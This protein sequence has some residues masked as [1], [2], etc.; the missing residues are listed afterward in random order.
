M[1]FFLDTAPVEALSFAF[2][3]EES[4]ESSFKQH[5][6]FSEVRQLLLFLFRTRLPV[7]PWRMTK[8]TLR[9]KRFRAMGR[10]HAAHGLFIFGGHG[11]LP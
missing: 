2:N 8:K 3:G 10:Q 9:E 11:P 1:E 7:R 6:R 5:G 4:D